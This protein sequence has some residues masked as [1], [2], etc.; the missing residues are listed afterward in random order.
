[1][2]IRGLIHMIELDHKVIGLKLYKKIKF[3]YFQNS[4]MNTF[5]RYLYQDNWID[6]EYEEDNMSRKGQYLAYRISYVYK[7]EAIGRFD[8]VTYYDK[9]ILDKSLHTFLNNLGHTMFLDLEMT[10]P[11]YTFKGKGFRTELI[12]AGI[13]ICDEKF[14]VIKKY[15]NYVKPKINK[16]LSKRAEDFLGIT[17]IEFYKRCIE[18]KKFYNDFNEML[19]TYSPAIVVFGKNDQLVLN[20]SY[21]I[22][23]VPSLKNKTRYINLC[24]LIKNYYELKNDPGLFKLLSVYYNNS[25]NQIHDALDDCEATRLVFLAFKDDILS[26]KYKAKIRETFNLN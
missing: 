6:L 19:F 22:N 24:Q 13:E 1:M 25:E 23:N 11:S 12:Q 17:S 10:M 26:N 7:I 20:D 21:D 18:Y 3:F 14:D 15:S 8:H 16:E 5:K 4:Q 9:N 2:R